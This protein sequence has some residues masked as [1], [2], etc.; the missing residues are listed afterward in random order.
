MKLFKTLF[1]TL[2]A[3]GITSAWADLTKSDSS[4]EVCSPKV[5]F[6]QPQNWGKTFIVLGD[7]VIEAPKADADG[8]ST[9]DFSKISPNGASFFFN[10]SNRPDCLYNKCITS[11]GVKNK[12]MYASNEGFTCASF[13]TDS[14]EV[15]IQEHPD[16]K[17]NWRNI[18]NNE[19]AQCQGIL[20]F[21]AA[22]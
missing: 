4:S 17:K 10:A 15:W 6:K 22:K 2:V 12:L 16:P 13:K 20:R 11:K 9:I 5:H 1:A 14:A 19:K 3:V 18:Y 7:S 8:W 21:L